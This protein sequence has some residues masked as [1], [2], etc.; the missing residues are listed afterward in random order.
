MD[1]NSTGRKT[2]NGLKKL[3]NSKRIF[4]WGMMALPLLQF[5]LFYFYVNFS[6]VLMAFQKY[7]P[8]EGELG[9]TM[10]FIGFTNFATAWEVIVNSSWRIMNSL[11]LYFFQLVVV[12]PLAII[13]SYYIAKKYPLSGLFRIMLYLP[14][15]ISAVVFATLYRYICTDVWMNLFGEWKY[16]NGLLAPN[17]DV[18]VIFGTVLFYNLWLAYGQNVMIYTSTMSSINQS[19]IE[20]AE[21]DGVGFWQELWYIYLPQVWPTFTT[22]VVLQMAAIFTNQ[23]G[24]FEIFGGAQPKEGVDTF[25]FYFYRSSLRSDLQGS[26]PTLL[27]YPELSAL[28]LMFTFVLIPLTLTTRKLMEKFGPSVE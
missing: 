25:G 1:M 19:I 4:Y 21:L 5:A 9:Y 3:E 18:S 23:M 8:N 20:S 14:T 13:F 7:V 17:T 24:L 15:I 26:E 16:P 11:T 6:S 12:T 28:G 10:Q 27:S 2:K 22:F